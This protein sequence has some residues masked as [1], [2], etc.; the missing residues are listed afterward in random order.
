M[1]SMLPSDQCGRHRR[2]ST[3]GIHLR[4]FHRHHHV[5]FGD[6]RLFSDWRHLPPQKRPKPPPRPPPRPSKTTTTTSSSLPTTMSKC[7]V[8]RI[9]G[10]SI[11]F[12]LLILAN[13]W[14]TGA[15]ITTNNLI[16]ATTSTSIFSSSTLNSINDAINQ[17]QQQQQHKQ[18]QQDEIST[19]ASIQGK[20]TNSFPR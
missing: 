16:S 15:T 18:Q 3:S 9:F 1:R 13:S 19:G 7:V 2:R 14:M 12:L 20:C 8:L 6:G 11:P 17:K 10:Q 5:R 4:L